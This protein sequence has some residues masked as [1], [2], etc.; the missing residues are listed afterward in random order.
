MGLFFE[1]FKEG[2]VFKTKSRTVT[3]T[4]I[5]MFSGL[6]GDYNALH[7]NEEFAKNTEHGTRIAHGMLV[8]SIATGL[9]YPLGITDETAIG[10]LGIN[11][12]KFLRSVKAGNT[13]R[14]EVKISEKR[15]SK[16]RK[17]AGIIIREI[18]ILN[19]KD[20]IV[21]R[22]MFALLVNKKIIS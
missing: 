22:G 12:F 10:F 17:D 2:D 20:E 15:E 9:M 14:V 16:S 4:D 11:E 21:Q 5:V 1:D 3:E 13:I 18:S 8:L 7:T 6:S 19:Q